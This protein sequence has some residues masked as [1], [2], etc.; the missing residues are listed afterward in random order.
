MC[1]YLLM[2]LCASEVTT[3]G[4][5]DRAIQIM[6]VDCHLSEG[7]RG[8]IL[9]GDDSFYNILISTVNLR[10]DESRLRGH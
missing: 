2:F 9:L 6:I 3:C 4:A 7:V 10:S 1:D 5:F 8:A